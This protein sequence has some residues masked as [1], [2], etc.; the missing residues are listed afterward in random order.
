MA[1]RVVV[2]ERRIVDRLDAGRVRID[3]E[4]RRSGRAV[5]PVGV[6]HH[7]VEVGDVA[8]RDEPFLA[9]QAEAPRAR[10]RRSS[11]PRGVGAGL[12]LG[13]GVGVL[14]LAAQDRAR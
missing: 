4:Q 7:D 3:Q 9:A 12:G 6:R 10:A 13:H 1:V 11:D 2:R 14:A 5:R 8:R